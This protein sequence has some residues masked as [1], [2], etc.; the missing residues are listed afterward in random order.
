MPPLD[1]LNNANSKE[2]IELPAQTT[3]DINLPM[4]GFHKIRHLG[5]GAFGEVALYHYSGSNPAY[6]NMCNSQGQIA[7]KLLLEPDEHEEATAKVIAKHSESGQL[8][9]SAINKTFPLEIDGQ[10]VG[11]LTEYESYLDIKDGHVTSFS[12][13]LYSLIADTFHPLEAHQFPGAGVVLA[14]KSNPA[15]F[16]AQIAC[17]LVK[18]QETLHQMSILHQDSAARNFLIR[19]ERDSDGNVLGIV[20]K[21]SDY[22]LTSILA[23]G[24]QNG[25]YPNLNKVPL[26]I[27]DSGVINTGGKTSQLTDY[28]AR[29]AAMMS[30][31]A[32]MLTA[33]PGELAALSL[34]PGT[35]Q[36]MKEFLADRMGKFSDN[37]TALKQLLNNVLAYLEQNPDKHLKQEVELFIQCYEPWLT[38]FPEGADLKKAR[39][40][41]MAVFNECNSRF[42]EMYYEHLILNKK[43]HPAENF[44]LGLQ[45]LNRIEVNNP[46]RSMIQGNI[47]QLERDM[48]KKEPPP[49]PEHRSMTH[50]E[51]TMAQ[52]VGMDHYGRIQTVQT[53]PPTVDQD[54]GETHYNN[55]LS[56]EA[57]TSQLNQGNLPSQNPVE[58]QDPSSHYAKTSIPVNAPATED[59]DGET[60]YMRMI[61]KERLTGT[62]AQQNRRPSQNPQPSTP[63][64]DSHYTSLS[65][66]QA[67]SAR[68]TQPVSPHYTPLSNPG[69]TQ[70]RGDYSRVIGTHTAPVNVLPQGHAKETDTTRKLKT[71]TPETRETHASHRKAAIKAI[72]SDF[73]HEV[74][75]HL[76]K[77]SPK[78]NV[79]DMRKKFK[80]LLKEAQT[81]IKTLLH[82][83]EPSPMDLPKDEDKH[84]D[85]NE[86][87]HL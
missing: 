67:Q 84:E 2:E 27:I 33:L 70:A 29:K 12:S 22:G 20:P 77:L 5:G 50:G 26:R 61:A 63:A 40:Q 23:E 64:H 74:E 17:G 38:F 44:L 3:K 24:E 21:I 49:T 58:N 81:N 13:N 83:K 14:L 54:D 71:A 80:T 79:E 18:G 45:R 78:D 68:E 42:V 59:N 35:T 62:T 85:D 52:P 57:I 16:L 48:A 11:I 65:R 60:H 9:L 39:E 82:I 56:K 37:N 87:L 53:A 8:D 47:R 19:T 32:Q 73:V 6:R 31:L 1:T 15:V 55:L 25:V 7:I 30:I 36:P 86:S 69:N 4:H 28:Y 76:E 46:I 43:N 66:A 41:E 75:H 34:K 10:V 72:W 51:R